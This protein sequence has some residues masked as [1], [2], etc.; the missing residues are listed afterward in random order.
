MPP[1]KKIK[2]NFTPAKPQSSTETDDRAVRHSAR[3]AAR[4]SARQDFDPPFDIE[5]ENQNG[6]D[7]GNIDEENRDSD[8]E[9]SEPESDQARQ[10]KAATQANTFLNTGFKTAAGHRVAQENPR[11]IRNPL[12]LSIATRAPRESSPTDRDAPSEFVE[13]LE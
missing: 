10:V 5:D 13:L 6:E 2:L 7:E 1:R 12:H 9:G 3:V 11:N 8:E 4:Q